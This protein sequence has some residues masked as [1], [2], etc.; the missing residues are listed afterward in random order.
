MERVDILTNMDFLTPN[1][2]Y[3]CI[4]QGGHA[5]RAIVFNRQGVMVASAYCEIETE[6]PAKHFVELNADNLIASIKSS[7]KQVLEDLG[8]NKKNI[9]S[10]GLATQRSNIVCWNK[11][12]G[13]A[14]SPI[15]SWQD[16][17]NTEWL[18]QFNDQNEH[19]HKITGLFMSPHY[20]A[21]KL[22]WC[23]DHIPEVKEALNDDTLAF[24]PMS[25]F[26][27]FQLVKEKFLLADPVNASRTQLWSLKKH[28][29]DDELLKLF[30]IPLSALPYCVPSIHHYGT[31]EMDDIN[32]PLRL[33]T[34]DQSAALYAYGHLQPDTAYVNTGTGA[35]V[36]RSSGPLALYSRRL[37]TS[38]IFRD[39][40]LR[41]DSQNHFVLEGTI[42]GAGS[43][44]DWLAKQYPDTN[45]YDK[46][47]E[48]LDDV[49]IPPLFLNG[50]S[51]LA[52]PFWLPNFISKFDR[53]A[54]VDEKAV[55]VVESII[56]L[57]KACLDE[58][59]KLSSPPEQIQITGGL[60]S[61][62]GLNQRLADLSG[63]PVYC[64]TECEATARGTAYLLAN[65]PDSWPEKEAGIWF[66]PEDNAELEK[67][68]DKWII[69]MLEHMRN[70]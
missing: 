25:S 61:L 46:L 27:V 68:Y 13:K 57:L 5:S 30:D 33:V 62:N 3:L 11:K 16:R 37:L 63:L 15:I 47:S 58:M 70:D 8:D 6:Y 48:W 18:E 2:L 56:F 20:G 52:A 60:A 1:S 32:I 31:I 12:T 19:I 51:G 35:F 42:N 26:I 53:Q 21:S 38:L 22:R 29:W 4:D 69:L 67:R 24:G 49:E 36:S 64:P 7:V 28:S 17:R 55:A 43:A 45:I 41:G 40:E 65:Q 39:S 14:L 44:L 50:V 54:N 9:V 66:E 34:G 10:A 59:A 23:L